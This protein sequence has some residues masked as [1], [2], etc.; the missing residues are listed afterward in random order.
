MTGTQGN[1]VCP[2]SCWFPFASIIK[3]LLFPLFVFFFTLSFVLYSFLESVFHPL[4]H[5]YFVLSGDKHS[6]ICLFL[7]CCS[8]PSNCII[9]SASCSYF[10]S[11]LLLFIVHSYLFFLFVSGGDFDQFM[12][13][14]SCPACFISSAS[15]SNSSSTLCPSLSL[16]Q[17]VILTN[18]AL[19]CCFFPSIPLLFT[20][21]S[22]SSYIY[23]PFPL[24]FLYFQQ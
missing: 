9:V 6:E 22:L 16:C 3:F 20:L 11:F 13:C 24:L 12:S 15:C 1:Q 21:S 23:Q 8:C 18:S 19:I 10:I 7:G 4:R 17:A 2:P 5:F 14:C